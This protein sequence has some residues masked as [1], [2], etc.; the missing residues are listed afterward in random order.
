MLERML[1]TKTADGS[2]LFIDTTGFLKNII[3]LENVNI[4]PDLDSNRV[5]TDS[6]VYYV[7]SQTGMPE[8]GYSYIARV[9]NGVIQAIV[10]RTSS[11]SA[12]SVREVSQGLVL[13]NDNTSLRLPVDIR[14]YHNGK[15]VEPD[16][17]MPLLTANSSVIIASDKDNN[18][19]GVVFDPVYSAPKVIT[20][21][22]TTDMLERL[23]GGK[24][25]DKGG[26]SI[27]PFQL[28]INDVVY[29]VG[30]I[31]NR[32]SYIRVVANEV[33]GDI[34]AIM[35]TLVSP[36]AIE[37]DGTK[38][39][40]DSSFPVRKINGSAAI[41]VGNTVKLLLGE[42]GKAVDVILGGTGINSHYA[43]VLDCYKETSQRSEDY[44]KT[45]YYVNLLHTDG[46]IKKYSTKDDS[47]KF[48]GNLVT[49]VIEETG[50]TYDTV[51][52]TAVEYLKGNSPY[53]INKDERKFGDNYVADNV[54]IFNMIHNVY[55]RNSDASIL[56][57]SDLPAGRLEASKVKYIH[58]S[59]DF[60]DIDVL[61]LD[62]VLDEGVFFGLITQSKINYTKEGTSQTITMLIKGKEYTFTG[63]PVAGA[64]PGYVARGRMSG[65]NILSIEW[66]VNPYTSTSVI[67]AADSSRIR[68]NDVTYRYHR[69]LAIYKLNTGNTW[70]R[71]GTSELSAGETSGVISVY[72]DKPLSN[73][74]KIIMIV[75][76]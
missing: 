52:L 66:T 14:Y 60:Q 30:D 59:G 46:N 76:R 67:Q 51:E 24:L 20:Q 7:K 5:L 33:T 12:Y 19:Y 10:S 4:R 15:T 23:Y 27:R 49:Y 13:L 18:R 6:G 29:E 58:T 62:N 31:W 37:I 17:V 26:K 21:Y 70:E 61:F 1:Q 50:E 9:D 2:K 72:L 65:G 48:K 55:G 28:E 56:K 47:A 34:T 45:Y 64:M 75:I 53:E 39:E 32:F 25:I 74:G 40:L 69:D 38:Y 43:L 36:S 22:M 16:A 3:I 42:N 63:D 68:I 73:G 54:I 71:V 41:G 44:G 11:L 57:W 8:L 35:P